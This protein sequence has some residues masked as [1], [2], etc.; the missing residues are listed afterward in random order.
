MDNNKIIADEAREAYRKFSKSGKTA[1]ILFGL[2][3]EK[4]SN[5]FMMSKNSKMLTTVSI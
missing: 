2:E 5:H 1:K 4:I 3:K